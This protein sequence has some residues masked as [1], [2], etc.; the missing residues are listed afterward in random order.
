MVYVII[1]ALF[2]AV[3]FSG[4]GA[5]MNVQ[6]YFY[7]SYWEARSLNK[8]LTYYGE[9]TDREKF[10]EL[11]TNE[12]KK[13]K[14]TKKYENLLAY[15]NLTL[16][17]WEE[18]Q[19]NLVKFNPMVPNYRELNLEPKDGEI[20]NKR[21]R[22]IN[23]III[24]KRIAMGGARIVFDTDKPIGVENIVKFYPIIYWYNDTFR[25][26]DSAASFFD[27]MRPEWEFM[28]FMR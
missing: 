19:K 3:V 23:V 20:I 7:P 10:R 22:S 5:S 4:C 21:H 18:I 27:I 9:W 6:K 13:N 8:N 1:S 25:F 12:K 16:N 17:D 15:F 26:D 14:I 2:V 11:M 28:G 24:N